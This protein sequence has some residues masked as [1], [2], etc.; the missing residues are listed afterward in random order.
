MPASMALRLL[1]LAR[2]RGPLVLRRLVKPALLM[3]AFRALLLGAGA[4]VVRRQEEEEEEEDPFH[5]G[6][7]VA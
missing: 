6:V 2:C 1:M 3:S 5:L 4:R 7:K